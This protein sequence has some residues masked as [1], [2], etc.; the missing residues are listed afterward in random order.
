MV[1]GAVFA[2][3]AAGL[4]A[5]LLHFAFV[6]KY[7]VL[8][9]QYESGTAVHFAGVAAAMDGAT[10]ETHS[11]DATATEHQDSTAT[12]QPHDNGDAGDASSLQRNAL[13][14]LFFVLLYAA[15]GLVLVA[16]FGL[17]QHFGGCVT[18]REGLLWGI[19]GFVCLHLA[20]A[21]GLAPELPGT[22]GPE[23]TDRQL[24]WA[25]TTVCTAV[26]LALIAYGR[27]PL[28]IAFAII[29]LAM[30]HVIGAPELEGF[31]GVAP[32]EVASAFAARTLAVGL[33]AWSLMGWLAGWYWD[34]AK[35]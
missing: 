34:R 7:I 16:G 30:P 27:K 28:W 9:E 26:A 6:Q 18:A 21:L 5:A 20:P 35:G 14:M 3:V 29:L 22:A 15:Y 10:T 31:S 2:G 4:F 13:T 25:A 17:A 33:A 11:H 23:L 1:T 8:G 24:W 32:P 19:A 12:A